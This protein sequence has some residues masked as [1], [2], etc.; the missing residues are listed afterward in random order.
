MFGGIEISVETIDATNGLAFFA[1]FRF[2]FIAVKTS[3]VTLNVGEM[4][5]RVKSQCEVF[6]R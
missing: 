2:I 3:F 1:R 6:Q 5:F 4:T